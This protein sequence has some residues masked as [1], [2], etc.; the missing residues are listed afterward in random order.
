[1]PLVLRV[2]G[3][4]WRSHLQSIIASHPGLVPVIKGNGYGFGIEFLAAEA[5]RLGVETIAVGLTSEISRVRVAF[6]GEVIVLSPEHGE[7]EDS[8]LRVVP[9][10]SNLEALQSIDPR[11]SIILEILTPLNRHGVDIHDLHNA[12]SI[13]N[14]RK[15]QFRGF[16]LH[17]PIAEIERE[18]LRKVLRTL[19]EGSTIWISHFH[20]APS[21]RKEFPRL[22]FRERIGTSLW[23][24]ADSALEVRATVLENRKIESTAG[25]RQRK[26]RGNVIVVSGGTAHGIGLS[27]PQGD[28][29]LKGRIKIL[30]RAIESAI[31]KL[32][33]P[34]S[35]RRKPL[36]F[37]ETPHMQCSL[38][39]HKGSDQPRPGDELEVRVR[40][41]TTTFDQVIIH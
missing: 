27:A 14:E 11:R 4:I 12:L 9:T 21:I 37:L 29:T 35:W 24:G 18:W 15:I 41:T 32:R 8:D 40:Y 34:F 33:S 31:G 10:I 38:L 23:L 19:P 25:Y 30:A 7:I 6:T 28:R 36:Y 17:L 3:N 22:N 1:M 39:L 2:N 26:V 13:I 5:N 16:A 20:D